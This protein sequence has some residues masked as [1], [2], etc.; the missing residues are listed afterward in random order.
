MAR[1]I[2]RAWKTAR[3]M[4]R[5]PDWRTLFFGPGLTH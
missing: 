4:L 5:A 1:K 3:K 2:R